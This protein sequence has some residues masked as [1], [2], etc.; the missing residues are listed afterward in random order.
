MKYDI[1][2]LGYRYDL[3]DYYLGLLLHHQCNNI[4]TSKT[5]QNDVDRERSNTY[6]LGLEFLTK[7]M[8]TGMKNCGI[9]FDSPNNFEF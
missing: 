5:Y 1:A 3:G 6:D 9:N 7:N 4:I 2:L 8:R